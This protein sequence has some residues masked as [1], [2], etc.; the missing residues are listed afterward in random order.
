MSQTNEAPI[1]PNAPTGTWTFATLPLTGHAINDVLTTSDQGP[2][3]WDGVQW[4]PVLKVS[5][6]QCLGFSV[7][8]L[9]NLTAKAGGG[10]ALA[11]PTSASQFNRVATVATA[12]DSVK[13]GPAVAG[14][15]A[16][17]YNGS[18]NAMQVFGNGTDTI[19]GSPAATGISQA[20][21]SMGIYVCF[22]SGQ[23]FK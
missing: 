12:N 3:V 9:D 21:N 18:A 17:L 20:G 5:G 23:W 13:L 15:L 16:I 22:S 1:F 8:A 14:S 4:F 2:C 7:T 6:L 11:T 10:Q 19:N